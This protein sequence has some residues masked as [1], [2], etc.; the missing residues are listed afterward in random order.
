MNVEK[1]RGYRKSLFWLHE[2][3][4]RHKDYERASRLR[5]KARE[6]DRR[7]VRACRSRDELFACGLTLKQVSLLGP[8]Q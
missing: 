4:M 3:S 6:F 8:L 5:Q 1:I 2:E 7:V